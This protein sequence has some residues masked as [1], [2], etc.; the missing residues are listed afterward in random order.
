[1]H[2]DGDVQ[3]LIDDL[4]KIGLNA[5]HPIEPKAMDINLLKK[6]YQNRLC[7]IGNIDMAGSLGRGTPDEV[8]QEVKERIRNVAPGGGY[9]V[10]SSN[11]V[12]SYI[13]I[14]NYRAMIEA[15]FEYGQYPKHKEI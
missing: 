10:G 1:M 11:S 2:T 14:E 8:R 3:P 12:A 4:V 6:K 5:L 15:T 7:L 9:A 13:P